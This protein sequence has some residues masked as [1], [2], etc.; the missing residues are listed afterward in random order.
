MATQFPTYALTVE[1]SD[2]I[3]AVTDPLY[4]PA[5]SAAAA[6]AASQ[7]LDAV[8][9]NTTA[10]FTTALNAELGTA[11]QPADVGTAAAEDVGFFAT[12]AQ[13]ALA[14]TATQPADLATVATTGAYTDLS[15]TPTLGTAAA[16]DTTDFA[17]AA[18]GA[19]ADAAVEAVATVTK[20]YGPITQ[21]AYDLLTP[22]ADTL[23]VIVG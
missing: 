21:A 14:D 8:L 13:G 19:T 9:T 16:A 7:P 12:A 2:A 10:S 17:T 3:T 4:D 18:Q 5:G 15:G 6:E 1:G 20:L 11:L 22:A 23:Y